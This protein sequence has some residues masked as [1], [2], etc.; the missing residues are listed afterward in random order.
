[1]KQEVRVLGVDDG[2]GGGDVLVVGT[3]FRGGQ[4]MDGLVSTR[5][6]HDGTDATGKIARMITQSKFHDQL[7]AVLLSG[8]SV[9]GFNMVDVFALHE[10]TGK[11]RDGDGK[12]DGG[13]KALRDR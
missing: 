3:F 9:G 13:D 7:Q 4:F 8:L 10:Q 12:E 11:C 5:V 6:E 2:P 1:M